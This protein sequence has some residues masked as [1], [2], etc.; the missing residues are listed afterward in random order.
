MNVRDLVS[1]PGLGRSPGGGHSN[2]LQYSCLEDPM[3]RGA[4]WGCKELDTTE[5]L[6][7]H[8]GTTQHTDPDT[9]PFARISCLLT[10]N[11]FKAFRSKTKNPTL[12]KILVF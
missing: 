5:R 9:P 12:G 6:N 3:D 2:P 7:T 11:L 8:T 1:M 4:W 10:C